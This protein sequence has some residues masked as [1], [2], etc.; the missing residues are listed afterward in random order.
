ME[1]RVCL[2]VF[3]TIHEHEN[4]CVHGR[5]YILQSKQMFK[6]NSQD[7]DHHFHFLTCGPSPPDAYIR[8]DVLCVQPAFL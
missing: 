1:N 5:N 2:F 7:V 3:C 4:I 6:I 8:F